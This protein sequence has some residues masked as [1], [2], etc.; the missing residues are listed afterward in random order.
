[1]AQVVFKLI[2]G[3]ANRHSR[4]DHEQSDEEK[5]LYSRTTGFHLSGDMLSVEN[6]K[7]RNCVLGEI[8]AQ[9]PVLIYA[10]PPKVGRPR[11]GRRNGVKDEGAARDGAPALPIKVNPRTA[12]GF[13]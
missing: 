7:E 3:D 6:K 13:R 11:R 5:G 12:G 4:K 1:M 2:S 10:A 8:L 9:E